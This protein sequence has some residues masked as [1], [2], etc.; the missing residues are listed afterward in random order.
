VRAAVQP[1][2]DVAA[3]DLPALIPF[4][5]GAR[6]ALELTFREAFRLGHNYIGTEHMLIALL[7]VD[8][9]S[10]ALAELGLDKTNVEQAVVSLL[11]SIAVDGTP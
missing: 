3:D 4:D 5:A 7:D 9:G 6:K 1:R 8:D 10:G 2:L 11:S